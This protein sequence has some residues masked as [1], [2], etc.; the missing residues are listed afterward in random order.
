MRPVT[1]LEYSKE[2]GLAVQTI[3]SNWRKGFVNIVG[4]SGRAFLMDADTP[5]LTR[6]T[7]TGHPI[8]DENDNLVEGYLTLYDLTNKF[9]V[10]YSR[11]IV[12]QILEID[13]TLK[14][15]LGKY[16]MKV[17][18][19]QGEYN[20]KNSVVAYKKEVLDYLYGAFELN[21][22]PEKTKILDLTEP[23]NTSKIYPLNVVS[24]LKEKFPEEM[25]K[26]S[27]AEVLISRLA[28]NLEAFDFGKYRNHLVY[29]FKLGY[30]YTSIA[31]IEGIS[32]QAVA[33]RL[34]KQLSQFLQNTEKGVLPCL[35]MGS[36][37]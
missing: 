2:S 19:F 4:V 29:Y 3:I 7:A 18:F 33:L 36:S 34:E 8:Y 27:E 17:K 16:T 15:D 23:M 22:N 11:K 25:S 30:T 21:N 37:E 10:R 24:A 5:I 12:N 6:D 20:I 32:K 13:D 9:N 26:Y 28:K 31:E 35:L 1:F 14:K